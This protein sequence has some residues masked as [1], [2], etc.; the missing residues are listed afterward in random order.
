MTLS[1]TIPIYEDKKPEEEIPAEDSSNPIVK[2][3]K[4]VGKTVE[5]AVAGVKTGVKTGVAGVKTGVEK[6]VAEI[7]KKTKRDG[8]TKEEKDNIEKD[9]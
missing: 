1:F 6:T 8:A 2:I 7:E 3:E 4:M 9:E 5:S